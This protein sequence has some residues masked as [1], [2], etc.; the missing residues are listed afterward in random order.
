L[1]ITDTLIVVLSDLHSG[2]TRALFPNRE[3]NFENGG[4]HRPNEEQAKIWKHFES[5]ASSI[6][7]ARKE[8]RLILIHDGD[9]IE[10]NPYNS[11]QFISRNLDDQS[12][13]HIEL[14]DWFMRE[15]GYD[16]KRGDLL[17]YIKGTE[18]HT[19]SKE[20][21]IG[22]DLGAEQN[23]DGFHAFDKLD[24]VVNGK[25]IQC[26]HHGPSRGKGANAGNSLRN[27]LKNIWYDCIQDGLQIPDVMITG[28]V[29]TPVY[30]VFIQD[31]GESYKILH[32]LICPSW[33]LKTRYAYKAAAVQLNKIG[34]VHFT[35]TAGG[36]ILPP[37][38]LLMRNHETK[39]KV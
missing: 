28:H 18:V 39:I 19:E 7:E 3:I 22:K 13:I 29:H 30:N 20:H 31:W 4:N 34:L 26:V 8:K 10:G 9:A 21:K 36:D 37:E 11:T 15:I 25:E 32:G 38:F 16:K 24:L 12:T 6:R 14:M 2:S 35:I 17:Y 33:Q 5:C 23:I 1:N 27:W